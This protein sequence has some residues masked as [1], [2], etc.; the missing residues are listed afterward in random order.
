MVRGFNVLF[1]KIKQ[2]KSKYIVIFN[3]II[4]KF[5]LINILDF[6]LMNMYNFF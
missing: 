2:K 3:S 5:G 4:M 1:L 6:V